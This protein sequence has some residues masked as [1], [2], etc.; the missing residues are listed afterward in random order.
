MRKFRTALL[1]LLSALLLASFGCK[2]QDNSIDADTTVMTVG[3]E[4]V[5]ALSY[6]YQLQSRYDAIQKNNLYDRETYLAYVVNPSAYYPYPY[7]DTRTEE[8]KQALCEGVLNELALEAAAIYTAKQKGYQLNITDQSY[9]TQ[10]EENAAEVL[11]ELAESYGSVE[12]FCRETGFTEDTFK[13]MYARSREASIDFSKL[14][15]DYRANNTISEDALDVGYR[16]IVK[17]TFVD[18]YTDGMY[19]QYLYYYITGA[20]SYPS[21]YIPDD[22]IFV[23]LFVHTDAKEEQLAAWTAQ[24]QENFETLYESADNEFTARGTAGDI[25]VAP[26]DELIE[27]L[28]EAAKD[29]AVGSVGSFST[30]KDGKTT[31]C[32]FLRTEGET[33]VVPIDRYPGVHEMIVNQ[34]SGTFCMDILR[35]TVADPEVATRNEAL[36][37]T[38]DPEG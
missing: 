6:R 20:R 13:R 11:E 21:L 34:L 26:K 1:L 8:G 24:A 2:K 15:E 35:L 36:L 38:I 3:D 7:Y 31:S 25:A 22:A 4:P 10:A 12:A 19:S 37:R 17:E 18:R 5:Y 23:R 27:G 9:I 29:V 30:V 14:L 28:Y 33:G 16:R 32:I